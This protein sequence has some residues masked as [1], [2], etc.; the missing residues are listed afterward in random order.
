MVSAESIISLLGKA[1]SQVRVDDGLSE[2]RL[3][4]LTET[5]LSHQLRK[6]PE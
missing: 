3:R 4:Y 2:W 1:D 5:L 6:S